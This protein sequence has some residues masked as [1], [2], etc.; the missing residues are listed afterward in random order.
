MGAFRV[1]VCV[2]LHPW[3]L[4]AIALYMHFISLDLRHTLLT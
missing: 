3:A 1:H 4:V 2:G